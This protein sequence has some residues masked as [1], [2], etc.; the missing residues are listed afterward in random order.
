MT[1]QPGSYV[2]LGKPLII[3]SPSFLIIKMGIITIVPI[4]CVVMKIR[5]HNV[6]NIFSRIRD[7]VSVLNNAQSL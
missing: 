2:T 7:T 3:L 6:G 1:L 4:S 5:Y